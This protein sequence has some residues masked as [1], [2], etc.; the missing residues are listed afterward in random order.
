MPE[1]MGDTGCE[2]QAPKL[3]NLPPEIWVHIFSYL[4]PAT[5]L[6]IVAPVS[7]DFRAIVYCDTLCKLDAA[8]AELH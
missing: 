1:L 8:D 6:R 4:E 2:A 5:L 7:Q 3:P